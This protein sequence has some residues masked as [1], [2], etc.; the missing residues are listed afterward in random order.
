LGPDLFKADIYPCAKPGEVDI[1]PIGI[2][3]YRIKKATVPGNGRIDRVF[4][5]IGVAGPVKRLILMRREVDPEVALA[6][7]SIGAITG[8][9]A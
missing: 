7:G 3:R 9:Q 4:K 8:E 2:F 5:A 1:D 6:F